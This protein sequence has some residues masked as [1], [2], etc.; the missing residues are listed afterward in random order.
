MNARSAYEELVRRSRERAV[1]NSCAS[2]LGWDEQTYLPR[3]GVEHRAQQ[4]AML[5]GMVHERAT[6]PKF[7]ELLASVEGTELTGDPEAPEAANVRE[8][9]RAFDRATKLPRDLVEAMAEATTLGQ[10]AWLAARAARDF[11]RFR[12]S[13]ERILDLKRREAACLGN[14]PGDYDALLDDYEPGATAA[15]LALL[16]DTLRRELVPLIVAISDAPRRLDPAGLRRSYPI[17][18]QRVFVEMMAAAVGFDFN[19]GRLDEAAHPFCTDIGPGDCRI[20]TRYRAD[21]FTDGFFSVL[22]EV[23]HALYEQGLDPTHYGTPMGES[24]SLGVHES[25]SRLWEN[26][27]GR[28]RAFWAFALPHARRVFHE[29]LTDVDL[30]AFHR[31]INRVEPSL[32]RVE[33]DEVTY[34]L[35]ILIRFELERA[36]LAGDLPASD[37]PGAW[38]EKYDQY[39]NVAPSN[40]AEG[41]LQDI[42]WSA[43]LFGYFPTYT[44]GNVY[45]AQLFARAATDLGDLPG[46]LERGEFSGLLGWLRERIH[47]QGKRLPPAALVE[48]AAHARPDP[49]PLAQA[50]RSKYGALYAV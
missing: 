3:G 16:F 9:R 15:S 12:P 21:D 17:G 19:R 43:G 48:R 47:R 27:V 29:A 13:F 42:H 34:N 46:A 25:Q 37:L 5:A 18:R 30:D 7:G 40:D 41:C 39:L 50:L 14:G 36:L 31:A 44:L 22:H 32:I 23:G 24:V 20:T 35:H 6:D 33:A 4:L 8:W 45:A 28:S 26:A 10:Q 1:L 2:L 49:E 38:T 11:A